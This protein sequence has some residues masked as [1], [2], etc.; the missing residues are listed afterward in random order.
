ME[1]AGIKQHLDAL[2]G[3]LFAL[4]VLAGDTI[5]AAAF[6]GARLSGV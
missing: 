4:G 5:G 1:C 6:L 3:S 2:A